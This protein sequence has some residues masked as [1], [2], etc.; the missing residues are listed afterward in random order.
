MR[1]YLPIFALLALL[2]KAAFCQEIIDTPIEHYI[3]YKD[4]KVIKVKI[5]PPFAI[6][7]RVIG[8][9]LENVQGVM[10]TNICT[11]ETA[12]TDNNGIYHIHAAKGDTL[13]F[14]IPKYSNELRGI[15][16]SRENLNIILIKRKA[17]SFVNKSPGRDYS[18][19]LSDDNELYR[20]L[21]KDAKLEGKWIY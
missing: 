6:T 4:P 10:V 21:E 9:N 1:K 16:P 18:K 20:I 5:N 7:G 17:D 8:M 11:A 2:S 3:V 15:K 12:K 14:V 13:A 19:A